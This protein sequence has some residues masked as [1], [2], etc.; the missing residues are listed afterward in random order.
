M[1]YSQ[2]YSNKYFFRYKND[3]DQNQRY[4]NYCFYVRNKVEKN[5][6]ENDFGKDKGK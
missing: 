3:Q 4:G 6:G 1:I 2:I 5:L